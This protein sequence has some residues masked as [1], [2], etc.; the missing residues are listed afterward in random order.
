MAVPV[1][2]YCKLCDELKGK[3]LEFKL[4]HAGECRKCTGVPQVH[5]HHTLVEKKQ[6]DFSVKM[7][8]SEREEFKEWQRKR[9]AGL[10]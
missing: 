3:K 5:H 2:Y 10:L 8:D 6:T 1:D 9:K 4:V 7:T